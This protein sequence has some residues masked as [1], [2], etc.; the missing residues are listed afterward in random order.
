M[1][2]GLW[3]TAIVA[4]LATTVAALAGMALATAEARQAAWIGAM[5][6]FA[7]QA[8]AFWLLFVWAFPRRRLLAHLLGFAVRFV[9]VVC[10]ALL[11]M[12]AATIPAAPVLLALV[13]VLAVATFFEPVVLQMENTRAARRVAVR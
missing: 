10:A 5:A 11:W 1:K 12:P 3:Y 9:V 2:M 8:A 4:M 6:G 7:V 13:T